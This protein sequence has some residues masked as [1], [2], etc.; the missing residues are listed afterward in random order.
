MMSN[1]LIVILKSAIFI[2][3][4]IGYIMEIC[5]PLPKSTTTI[6]KFAS[7]KV[8]YC[9]FCTLIFGKKKL[10]SIIFV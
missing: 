7:F 10:R 8:L 6:I 1:N 5:I 4:K 3:P 2:R 9:V